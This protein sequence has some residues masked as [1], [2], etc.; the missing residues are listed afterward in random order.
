MKTQVVHL[1]SHDD[2]ISTRDK[3]GWKQTGRILLVWPR[4]GR[5][6]TRR[7]DLILI[8]RHSAS[9]GAQLALVTRDPVVKENA[10]SLGI[11]VFASTIEAQKNRW[12]RPSHWRRR[13]IAPAPAD[14]SLDELREAAHPVPS[15]MLNLPGVRLFWFSLGVAAVL[16]LA[17][18]LL[19][20]AEITLQ[21]ALETQVVT[22][23]VRASKDI[24]QVNLSGLLPVEETLIEVE[25][26]SSIP[27]SGRLLIPD[28]AAGGSVTFTNLTVN[29]VVI[30]AGTVVRTLD[31][32][33]QRFVTTRHATLRAGSGE[34]LTVP[35]QALAA[36]S[37]GNLPAGSLLAIE[38]PLGLDLTVTNPEPT[39]GGSSRIV[40]AA[41]QQDQ[42]KLKMR[43]LE[44]LEQTAITE[45]QRTSH[46]EDLLLT[47]T[48]ELVEIIGETFTPGLDSPADELELALR[49]VYA[50]RYVP[51][52][53]VEQLAQEV[54][55]ARLKSGFAA[56]A[57]SLEIKA[58]NQPRPLPDGSAE[59]QIQAQRPI[60]P[61]PDLAALTASLA[62]KDLVSANAYLEEMKLS[63]RA[64]IRPS[65]GW[66]PR[67]PLLPGRISITLLPGS[68]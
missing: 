40:S 33:P 60:Y 5:I 22:I 17:A 61:L 62:G 24:R 21:P 12:A 25:G 41:S 26:R 30:P 18:V 27:T 38:G 58:L 66:W 39:R 13:L 28:Q 14:R 23:Q 10:R 32:P 55:D 57:G 1:D 3:L 63:E 29:P 36:G 59:W 64:I 15:P 68:G 43:L 8:T 53:A 42:S 54:L 4:K 31:L 37:D 19:P 44:T 67:L 52:Q 6:L 9:L 2:A 65:P 56:Q 34:S 35:V 45:Y 50:V 51:A 16:A 48:P 7:L 49:V 20:S 47:P 46:P 11:S